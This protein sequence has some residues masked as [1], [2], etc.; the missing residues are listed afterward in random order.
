MTD[1]FSSGFAVRRPSWHRKETLHEVPP[2]DWN[3]ACEWAGLTDP[4]ECPIF[5]PDYQ[6]D[7]DDVIFGDAGV[8]E[9]S[10]YRALVHPRTGK[11]MCIQ[12]ESY[13]I[14]PLSVIGNMIDVMQEAT[15]GVALEFDTVGSL[16]EG[17]QIFATMLLDEPFM[18]DGDPSPHITYVVFTN[19]YD[20]TLPLGVRKTHIRVVCANTE[21]YSRELAERGIGFYKVFKH[22]KNWSFK[23]DDA[24]DVLSSTRDSQAEYIE[25]AANMMG[26]SVTR[27]GELQFVEKLIGADLV[28]GIRVSDRVQT[29]IDNDRTT[30]MDILNGPTMT[31]ICGNVYGLI[32]AGNEFS[33]HFGYGRGDALIRRSLI[34]D[35][36]RSTKIEEFAFIAARV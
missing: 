31:G 18:I 21:T 11:I 15:V 29:N 10:D 25:W 22:T 5:L 35:K 4:V 23:V 26:R 6:I 32:Q 30:L 17:K 20:G 24:M 34:G 3:Q 36:K 27:E 13:K 33:Q 19:S 2:Q 7:G 14:I 28:K 12:A 8:N 1:H 9:V 16:Y